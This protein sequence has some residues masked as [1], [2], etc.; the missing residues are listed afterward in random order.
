MT[1][2]NATTKEVSVIGLGAM[3]SAIARLLLESGARVTVWNRTEAKAE[4]LIQQ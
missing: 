2:I 1:D 4:P 3:G